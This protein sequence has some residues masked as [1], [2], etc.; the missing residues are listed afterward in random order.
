MSFPEG[1]IVIGRITNAAINAAATPI[2]FKDVNGD[3]HTFATG[4]RLIIKDIFVNNRAT[5]KDVTILQDTDG[6]ADS[7][8]GEEVLVMSFG[9]A[10]SYEY[11]TEGLPTK[12]IN[13]GATNF[14]YAL[15]SA[16]GSVDIL[17]NGQVV[18]S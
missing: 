12:R 16:A 17:V 14:F 11:Y 2:V 8:S 18:K 9:A 3:A 13:A 1:K 15:G 7:D 10:G 6:G 5:A 4:E